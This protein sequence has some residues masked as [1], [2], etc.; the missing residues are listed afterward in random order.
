MS[1]I[2]ILLTS[3]LLMIGG[4]T[5]AQTLY[6]SKNAALSFFSEAPIEDIRGQAS[7]GVSALDVQSK[8]VYFKV[9]IRSFQFNKA[10]MQEHFNENYLESSK[11]P[12]AEFKGKIIDSID[13]S[14]EGS[15]S[16]KVRGTL[17][18]HNVMKEYIVKADISVKDGK[19][20]AHSTFPVRLADHHIK[21]P[22]IVIKN[23][24]EVVEISVLAVYNAVE[25]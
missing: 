17:N 5:K 24:A 22:R 20:S 13:L 11:Y 4:V 10:L 15:Y 19:V 18:L 21:I 8:A 23:I 12:Y 16:V 1:S 6:T 25:R 14:R 2:G 3:C 9:K 7:D